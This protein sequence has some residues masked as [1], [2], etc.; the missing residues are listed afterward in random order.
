MLFESDNN[1]NCCVVLENGTCET[2]ER[3]DFFGLPV[4]WRSGETFSFEL[5]QVGQMAVMGG[6]RGGRNTK[7]SNKTQENSTLEE[8]EH[9]QMG[10]T[11]VTQQEKWT[12]LKH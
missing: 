2:C 9:I 10:N 11:R 12:N 4:R 3:Q 5:A 1:R 8:V 7:N 6:R